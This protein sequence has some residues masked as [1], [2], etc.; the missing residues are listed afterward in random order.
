MIKQLINSVKEFNERLT[1]GD[2]ISEVI[3]DNEVLIIELNTEE[4]LY[5]EGINILGVKI[6]DYAPYQPETIYYKRERGQPTNRV[7]LRDEGDFHNSFY[8]EIGKEQFEIKASDE[9]TEQLKKKY[10][11]ILGLTDENV[12]ELR[13]YVLDFLLNKLNETVRS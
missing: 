3:K 9:K 8:L 6:D 2:Y 4:Q 13:I 11:K 5:E 12:N 10:G 7:T 1:N